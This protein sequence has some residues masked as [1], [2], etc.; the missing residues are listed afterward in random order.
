MDTSTK[1]WVNVFDRAKSNE[2]MFYQPKYTGLQV[3][4]LNAKAHPRTLLQM[5][6]A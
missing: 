2:M 4:D 3:K 1:F 6:A 5:V